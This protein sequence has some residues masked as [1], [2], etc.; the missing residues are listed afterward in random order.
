LNVRAGL[1][2]E[3]PDLHH[4][5]ACQVLVVGLAHDMGMA[6]DSENKL[7]AAPFLGVADF[8]EKPDDVVPF[9]IMGQRMAKYSFE[10]ATV[11]SRYG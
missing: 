1:H 3:M 10:G 9:E 11:R 2:Q 8:P 7:A 6:V 5:G 4:L